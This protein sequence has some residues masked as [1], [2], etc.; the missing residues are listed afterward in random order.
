MHLTAAAGRSILAKVPG[1]A[2][3]SPGGGRASL[4]A[5]AAPPLVIALFGPHLSS[6]LAAE[7]L[8]GGLRHPVFYPRQT[9][10]SRQCI[11]PFRPDRPGTSMR[12]SSGAGPLPPGP[13]PALCSARRS[14]H[15]NTSALTHAHSTHAYTHA[16]ANSGTHTL[17]T[18]TQI[19]SVTQARTFHSHTKTLTW[20]LLSILTRQRLRCLRLSAGFASEQKQA[21]HPTGKSARDINLETK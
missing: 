18:A 5:P 15:S 4:T 6:P 13:P 20:S 7:S 19:D 8:P 17:L 1:L 10:P 12:E 3:P 14:G 16:R 9:P 21:R 2:V 11:K